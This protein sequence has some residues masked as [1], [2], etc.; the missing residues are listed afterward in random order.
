MGERRP[1]QG[2]P[3]DAA[4]MTT[5][6]PAADRLRDQRRRTIMGWTILAFGAVIALAIFGLLISRFG[7]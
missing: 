6:R 7:W 5:L 4:R 3:D 1:S 2:L